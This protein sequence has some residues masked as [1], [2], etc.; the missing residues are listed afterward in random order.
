VDPE[1]RSCKAELQQHHREL[2]VDVPGSAIETADDG[3]D[4][5]TSARAGR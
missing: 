3:R 1:M 4:V 5:E 2:V